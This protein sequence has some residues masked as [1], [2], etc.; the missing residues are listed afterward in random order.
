MIL[1]ISLFR[2]NR[3]FARASSNDKDTNKTF[4]QLYLHAVH[5]FN[6]AK[7]GVDFLSFSL[8]QPITE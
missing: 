8:Q 1:A 2:G 3:I 5:K 4:G 6:F 7:Q